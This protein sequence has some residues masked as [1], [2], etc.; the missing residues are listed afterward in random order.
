ML[1]QINN[2]HIHNLRGIRDLEVP[3]SGRNLLIL[4]ENG[5]G[6][7][8]VI[9]AVELFFTEQIERLSGRQDVLQKDAIP[10]W[11]ADKERW[12]QIGFSGENEPIQFMF[13]KPITRTQVPEKYKRFFEIA[14]SRPFILHRYKLLAFIEDR[15]AERY[16]RLSALIGMDAVDDIVESWKQAHN[17]FEKSYKI[18]D[19]ASKGALKDLQKWIK[20][21]VVSDTEICDLVNQSIIPLGLVSITRRQDIPER[22]EALKGKFS[23]SVDFARAE[24]LRTILSR[25][26]EMLISLNTFIDM[27]EKLF[28]RWCDVLAKSSEV[29]D[30]PYENIL[31]DG[32]RV[33]DELFL[34]ICPL[35]ESEIEN[36]PQLLSRIDT[37]LEG[38]H[39]L[40][41]S[42]L[43]M[44]E[45]RGKTQKSIYGL[46]EAITRLRDSL[47]AGAKLDFS[48]LS[49]IR[50][51]VQVIEQKLDFQPLVLD[52]MNNLK[53]NLKLDL[54][55]E[56][57]IADKET[58]INEA[59]KLSPSESEKEILTINNFL[60][61]V[62]EKWIDWE[63]EREVTS[64]QFKRFNQV[65]IVYQQLIQARKD[66][67]QSIFDGLQAEFVRL[68]NVLHPGEGHKAISIL[69]SENKA[70]SADLLAEIDGMKPTHPL[71]HYSEGHLDSMG[72]CIFL[73]FIKKFNN[74]LNFIVLDDVLTSIDA[75][76]RLRV[77]QLIATEFK[78]YQIIITTHDEFWA[79]EL[80]VVFKNNHIAMKTIRM[81]PWNQKDGATYSDYVTTDWD[82]YK[83]Q[84]NTGNKLDAIAG[85]GRS[86]ERFLFTMRRNFH[87]EVPATFDDRYTI[88]DLY[89]PFFSWLSKKKIQRQDVKDFHY[90]INFLVEELDDY[91]RFRNWSGAH[92]NEWGEQVSQKEAERFVEIVQ[93][94]VSAMQCPKCSALVIYDIKSKVVR[95]PNCESNSAIKKPWVY[96]SRWK[97]K[98]G[99][100]LDTDYKNPK[101]QSEKP[102]T[103]T[104]ITKIA[105][106]AFLQD[107]RRRLWWNYW[108]A[109]TA[110]ICCILTTQIKNIIAI[111]VINKSYQNLTPHIGLLSR[112]QIIL[113]SIVSL[114][115]NRKKPPLT[116]F[117][118]RL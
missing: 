31:V 54:F 49:E 96:N 1:G 25:V 94:I 3:L 80:S 26:E 43:T 12:V 20:K 84:I 78:D 61:R 18:A 71:A 2:I 82:Y 55:L 98:A 89:G 24:A 34:N 68:Y 48:G 52:D 77:A 83:G 59:Q 107:A 69:M 14:S 70:N 109:V 65:K 57:V 73:A 110:T 58:I 103:V 106:D 95:C 75:G 112:C 9:D 16:E 79:N 74:D 42:R 64:Q 72:L 7:S 39:A 114:S 11:G 50:K 35:C 118:F 23:Q 67:V 60:A 92:Y 62:D 104:L 86:L 10:F 32:K 97:Q 22:Q 6:K 37:R 115:L 40:I 29:S 53:Q 21:D 19:V 13:S 44:E 46:Q 30:A 38:L 102:K 5:T 101:K 66:G 8:S 27:Y 56:A 113:H 63:K 85:V 33:I 90:Q 93:E 105:F 47:A 116:Y 111:R 51:K 108:N 81:N 45:Q 91:W 28:N 87:L 100:I 99:S 41:H 36:K 4:G 17:S 76:H 88:G 15:A 117:R